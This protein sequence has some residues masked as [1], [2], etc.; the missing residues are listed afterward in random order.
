MWP[1]A[2]AIHHAIGVT[3]RYAYYGRHTRSLTLAAAPRVLGQDHRPP[4]DGRLQV[5][6]NLGEMQTQPAD[7][8][9]RGWLLSGMLV[10]GARNR[11][12]RQRCTWSRHEPRRH[13]VHA[14]ASTSRQELDERALRDGRLPFRVMAHGRPEV[15]LGAPLRRRAAP[16]PSSS[17]GQRRWH[18][19]RLPEQRDHRQE[20][21]SRSRR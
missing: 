16:T 5:V 19:Y 7:G 6:G 10:A 14:R 9:A 2:T 1:V 17:C 13:A 18:P 3:M 12:Y 8:T 21:R 11:Q 15:V 4:G 20:A